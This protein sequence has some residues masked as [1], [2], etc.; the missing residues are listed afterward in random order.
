MD[1]T[2]IRVCA[3]ADTLTLY[4]DKPAG[5]PA[6]CRY[7]VCAGGR[8]PVTV[9]HTHCT[10]TG[11]APPPNIPWK[12]GWRAGP[13][14]PAGPPPNRGCPGWMRGTS[15]CGTAAPRAF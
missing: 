4:W 15:P 2:P 7:E 11:L 9:A 12:S 14:G 3:T 8:I 6:D 1:D 13:W 5:A 10:L